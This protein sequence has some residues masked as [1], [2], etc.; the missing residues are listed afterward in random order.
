[1]RCHNRTAIT[2][3]GCIMLLCVSAWYV[4][5]SVELNGGDEVR[6]GILN[7]LVTI[8]FRSIGAI[9]AKDDEMVSVPTAIRL[10][11]ET[12]P[13]AP[14]LGQMTL[15]STSVGVVQRLGKSEHRS[16][17]ALPLTGNATIRFRIAPGQSADL[18]AT[19]TLLAEYDLVLTAGSPSIV[20]E[21]YDISPDAI[22]ALMAND[23]TVCIEVDSQFDADLSIGDVIFGFGGTTAND[24]PPSAALEPTTL[25]SGLLQV[26]IDGRSGKAVRA[27]VNRT[28][29][30][31]S[32]G[33]VGVL[34]AQTPDVTA[35]PVDA[36]SI[37]VDPLE[38][39][40]VSVN[41]LYIATHSSFVPDVAN[42][43]QLAT[44]T[45]T[46]KSGSATVLNLVAGENTAEW[47]YDRPEHVTNHGGV[48]H[49]KPT[50]LYSFAT[51]VQSASTYT[52]YV[53]ALTLAVDASRTISSIAL[54]MAD[55]STYASSRTSAGAQATWAGQSVSG[56]TLLGIPYVPPTEA[57]C[58]PDGHCADVPPADCPAHF[59]GDGMPQGA[60]TSCADA[61]C[62]SID[63]VT[64]E[65]CCLPPIVMDFPGVPA[66]E[67][68][69]CDM[70]DG[71]LPYQTRDDCIFF[72]GIPQGPG[73][74]CETVACPEFYACCLPPTDG[75][76]Y[77]CQ[78][79]TFDDC[80]QQGGD[81]KAAGVTCDDNP[82]PAACCFDDGSCADH[83]PTTCIEFGG[84]PGPVESL[85]SFSECLGACCAPDGCCELATLEACDADGG[86]YQGF[87][88]ECNA[89]T[90]PEAYGCFTVHNFPEPARYMTVRA[91]CDFESTLLSDLPGGGNDPTAPA[92][93]LDDVIPGATW[94]T[95]EEAA[96]ECCKLISDI[97]DGDA[98]SG[99]LPTGTFNGIEHGLD[100]ILVDACEVPDDYVVWFTGNVCCWGAPWIYISTRSTFEEPRLRSS[101]SGG[102]IDPEVL[103]IKVEIMGGFTDFA[104]AQAWICPKF[105][106]ESY[107]YWC[108]SHLQWAGQNW[109]AG[110]LGC[111][112]GDLEAPGTYPESDGCAA[113]EE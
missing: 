20:D 39:G 82:C 92:L 25:P 101:F 102:G 18:C 30:G 35:T 62:A 87:A 8:T 59:D 88:V 79:L 63:D 23:V 16:A 67:G 106:S 109:R 22:A 40:L 110:N 14:A 55:P 77:T 45:V 1:M 34:E 32:Y 90:C 80:V 52:G 99:N 37:T 17:K 60:G 44:L 95:R 29:G 108:G 71:T 28:I 91:A 2:I 56:I 12:P 113:Y 105:E 3:A 96:S 94:P 33:I 104:E 27:A 43:V 85:C 73:T 9:E 36:A 68:Y 57:C 65:A 46:Y 6:I 97:N 48:Q 19:A 100:Q 58:A 50:A 89:D 15:P 13:Q 21:T 86:A 66:P 5:C 26:P 64:P 72:G 112:L 38:L 10:F 4:G 103:A 61:N 7:K 70:I 51:S 98:S 76:G 111:D 75:G 47:S 81:P 54:S 74:T 31:V 93:I 53:Y 24:P 107:H 78:E 11:E 41:T 69:V 83:V 84:T 49:A 42:G